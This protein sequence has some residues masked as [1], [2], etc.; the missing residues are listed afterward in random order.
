MR[1]IGDLAWLND[2][3]GIPYRFAGRDM[4]GV[5][6]YGL[7]KLIYENEYGYDMPDWAI[8]RIDLK[9][10]HDAIESVVTSGAFTETDKPVDG[11]LVVCYRT[12]AACH[13]GVYYANGVIHSAENKSVIYE[14][15][16][17]FS[18]AYVKLIIG[19]WQP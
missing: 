14:P 9:G 4:S 16:S 18:R 6:C 2:Y 13:V 12:K 5:D 1:N 11:D 17:R 10:R 15:L 7:V 3:I 19:D 8:D